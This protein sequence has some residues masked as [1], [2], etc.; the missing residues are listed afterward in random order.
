M[1]HEIMALLSHAGSPIT[2]IVVP[3]TIFTP[4][5]CDT[6]KQNCG[7]IEIINHI[8]CMVKWAI[9]DKGVMAFLVLYH[10]MDLSHLA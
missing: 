8:S 5:C 3:S 7:G 4:Q 2:L 9:W 1:V 6:L 10:K